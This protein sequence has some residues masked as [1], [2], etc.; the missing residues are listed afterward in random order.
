MHCG[1]CG[2]QLI[3]GAQFCNKCGS[4]VNEFDEQITSKSNTVNGNR[5][6]A[7]VNKNSRLYKLTIK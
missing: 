6:H 5:L 7:D 3:E 1:N 4:R 2:D